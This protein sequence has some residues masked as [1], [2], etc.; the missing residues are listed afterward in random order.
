VT[1]R[2]LRADA[3]R[4]RARLL[5]AAREAFAAEG[6][7]VPLDEIARRAGVG[8]GTLY[9]HFP[10]K[11]AL[12]EAVVDDRLR[13]LADTARGLRSAEDA[14]A[15]LFTLIDRLAAE[16]AVK[17]D[18]VDALAGA[19]VEVRNSLAATAGDLRE[20]IG[21]LLAR[22]QRHGAV[23]PDLDIAD[24][25]ALLSGLFAALTA[26]AHRRADP[27]RA[28]AVLRAGLRAPATEPV[29]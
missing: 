11:E 25:M 6:L 27:A 5:E 7:A 3:R 17:K 16:A 13:D 1:E 14:G 12:F 2:P 28:L 20:E 24:L 10:T 4:N 22:A 8:P 9:R 15:A 29:R 23:R 21:H 19:G 18:L 26:P